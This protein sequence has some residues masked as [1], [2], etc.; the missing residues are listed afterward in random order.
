MAQL[1]TVYNGGKLIQHVEGHRNNNQEIELTLI[2]ETLYK[3]IQISSDHH[4]MMFP[5]NLNKTSYEIIGWSKN[6]QS[7]TYLNGKNEE[8]D[9][10]FNFVETEIIYYPLK[11]SLCIQGHPEWCV[12]SEGADECIKLIKKHLFKEEIVNDYYVPQDE[13]SLPPHMSSFP[14]GWNVTSSTGEHYKFDGEKFITREIYNSKIM[15]KFT[16]AE[17]KEK[18]IEDDVALEELTFEK[19]TTIKKEPDIHTIYD[20]SW[21][22][23][24]NT[25]EF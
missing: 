25:T 8:I 16:I 9:L 10:P 24:S 1:L 17:K 19:T 6:F 2:P 22:K 20:D 5:F 23:T 7:N 12:G 15:K 3:K 14:L 13:F 4:Q 18:I 21:N 11:N